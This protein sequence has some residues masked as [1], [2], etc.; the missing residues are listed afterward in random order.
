MKLFTEQEFSDRDSL[1]EHENAYEQND[2][3]SHSFEII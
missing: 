1:T 2:N 3:S